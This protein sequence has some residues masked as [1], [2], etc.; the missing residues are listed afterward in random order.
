MNLPY[1]KI[2]RAPLLIS[3]LLVL[4]VSSVLAG[5]PTTV[6]VNKSVLINLK[7]PARYVTIADK[8]IIEVPDPLRR[9]QLLINGRKIGSTNMIVWEEN[10]EK[11]TFFDINVVGD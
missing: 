3:L 10:V 5:V 9:N 2:Y 6:T 11:P 1:P 4:N 8:D 7:H